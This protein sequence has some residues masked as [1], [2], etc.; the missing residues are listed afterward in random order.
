MMRNVSFSTP[1]NGTKTNVLCDAK[2][3]WGADLIKEV[4]NICENKYLKI[5]VFAELLKDTQGKQ[6][7]K[8]RKDFNVQA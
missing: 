1:N 7:K 4:L 5:A 3:P 6:V 2:T 8:T